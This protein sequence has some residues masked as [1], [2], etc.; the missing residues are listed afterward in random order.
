MNAPFLISVLTVAWIFCA[1]A[2]ADPGFLRAETLIDLDV[3]ELPV[4]SSGAV[5]TAPLAAAV[6]MSTPAAVP[7]RPLNEWTPEDQGDEPLD[8]SITKLIRRSIMA[9]DS[10]SLSAQ[11]VKIITMNGQVVLRGAVPSRREK[12]EIARK[13]EKIAGNGHVQNLLEVTG[14]D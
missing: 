14:L 9:D 1:L 5:M 2:L 6:E 4:S 10:M 3:G 8:H 12:E 7:E 13:A 11:N